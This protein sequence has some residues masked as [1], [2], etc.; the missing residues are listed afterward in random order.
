MKPPPGTSVRLPGSIVAKP[1]GACARIGR[2]ASDQILDVDLLTFER[3]SA[4][5]RRAI[6]DGVRRSLSTGF[7][8]TTSDLSATLLDEAYG[9]LAQF[10]SLPSEVKARCS[11]PESHGQA[12]YT[13]VGVET[14]AGADRPDWKEMLNWGRQVD[15]AHPLRRLFPLQYHDVVLPEADIPGITVVLQ[16]FGARLLELQRRFLRIV[17]AGLGVAETFFDDLVVDGATLNRAIRYPP[18]IQAGESAH[19]WADGHADINLITALPR[20]S[21]PGLQVRTTQGWQDAE[22]PDGSVILN[23]G[24]MLERLTNGLIPAGWHRVVAA[25]GYRGE[26]YSMV[27]FCHP[28]PW[29]ILSPL[30]SCICAG[31]PQRFGAIRAGDLLERVLWEINLIAA[32]PE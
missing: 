12:G 28:A 31:R 7:V 20:A 5:K 30:P 29:M 26:R 10:F 25:A 8:Y 24:I 17:G 23:T 3:G 11:A 21:A 27:Q 18:M 1:C 9:M 22:P 2:M 19:V 14:A 4:A 16:T 32:S 15:P 13:G 6:V